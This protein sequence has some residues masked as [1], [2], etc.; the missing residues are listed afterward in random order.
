MSH[1][2]PAERPAGIRFPSESSALGRR[3]LYLAAACCLWAL[4]FWQ[5]AG[6]VAAFLA[7]AERVRMVLPGHV[8]WVGGLPWWAVAVAG[9]LAASAVGPRLRTAGNAVLVGLPLAAN[10]VIHLNLHA[11][12]S[13]AVRGLLLYH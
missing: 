9:S 4:A 7:E 11:A 2:V 10:V 3:W 12:Q 13:A 5:S 8:H 6:P 1:A